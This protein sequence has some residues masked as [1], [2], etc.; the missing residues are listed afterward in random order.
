MPPRSRGPLDPSGIHRRDHPGIEAVRLEEAAGDEPPRR[1]C[2]EPGAGRNDEAH[3][4]RSIVFTLLI[5]RAHGAQKARQDRLM[6]I[7]IACRSPAGP[8]IELADAAGELG[9]QVLPLA[10][11][12]EREEMLPAPL[13]QLT[14][15]ERGGL[16]A[17]C[18]PEIEHGKKI[19]A[20]I[21]EQRVLLLGLP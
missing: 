13:A 5:E 7:R 14:A 21:G 16:L 3:A 17:E 18:A 6:Q 4:A 1:L 12:Q 9:V 8:Q 2:R 19:G 10:H 20:G 15:G 11:A